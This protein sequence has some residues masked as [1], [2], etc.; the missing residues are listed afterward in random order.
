MSGPTAAPDAMRRGK[1]TLFLIATA[2]LA[3]VVLSYAVYH[4][5][6]PGSFTNYGELLPIRPVAALTGTR[7]DR[8]PFRMMEMQGRWTILLAAGGVCDDACAQQLHATRQ[9]RIMQ[10][11]ER[12]RIERVWLVSDGV[13]PD[14]ALLAEHPDVVVVQTSTAE[15]ALLPKGAQAIHLVDPLG[16]Q[17]LAWPR[18]PDIKALARDLTRLLKASRIG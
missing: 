7:P 14:A 4:L 10:G 3:P 17:V 8:S 12:E 18:Q 15:V 6:P 16:N 13:R 11:R 9:A 2:F 5:S 1:R